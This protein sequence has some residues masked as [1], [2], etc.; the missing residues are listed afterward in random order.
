MFG[1]GQWAVRLAAELPEAA[2]AA[3]V[4]CY[5]CHQGRPHPVSQPGM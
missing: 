3:R 2:P 5:T 1:D 4:T